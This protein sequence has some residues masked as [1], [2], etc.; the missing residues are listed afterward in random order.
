[1]TQEDLL[2]YED[3]S[4]G[5]ENTFGAFE[6]TADLIR[7]YARQW[8]PQP[9]HLDEELARNSVLGGLCASGWQVCA[10]MNRLMVDAY[11][12]R[13]AGMGSFGLR[14]VKWMK[15]VYAGDV[16][17]L[18]YKVL[19]KR[20]SGSRPE[21]GIVTMNWQA[22]DQHGT[23][24]TEMTGVNLFKVRHVSACEEAVS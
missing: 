18:H 3:F 14:E 15:P 1:M 11:A 23:V 21:M 9:F 22:V 19:E 2:H 20:I 7:E 4:F 10:I 8:D 12:A 24:K 17:T 16:L 6:V 5:E 13:A